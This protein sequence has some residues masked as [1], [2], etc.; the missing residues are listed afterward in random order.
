MKAKYYK[1]KSEAGHAPYGDHL[2]LESKNSFPVL[3]PGEVIFAGYCGGGVEFQWVGNEII[4]IG[5]P[6]PGEIKT[7]FADFQGVK[8]NVH[9]P[10]AP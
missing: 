7:I 9:I 6:Q 3:F 4:R 5:C 8:L 2:I 10:S 1:S